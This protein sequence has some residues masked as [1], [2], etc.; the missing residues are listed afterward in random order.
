MDENNSRAFCNLEGEPMC[1]D[2][3]PRYATM[4]DHETAFW[5]GRAAAKDGKPTIDNPYKTNALFDEQ[6]LAEWW[7]QG[8][9]AYRDAKARARAKGRSR[10]WNSA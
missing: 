6:Q 1:N 2:S 10:K 3:P 8:H 4:S 7:Y 9:K 5:E